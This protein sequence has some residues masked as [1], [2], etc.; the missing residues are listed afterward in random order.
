[1]IF[2]RPWYDLT[3]QQFDRL[4]LVHWS[5]LG[6]IAVFWVITLIFDLYSVFFLRMSRRFSFV[7]AGTAAIALTTLLC[8][9]KFFKGPFADVDPAIIP[10]WLKKVEEVQPLLTISTFVI[11]LQLFGSAVLTFIFLFYLM[12]TDRRNECR[13]GW[14]FI[15]LAAV[16]FFLI[17]LYQIR[18]SA[19]AQIL[20]ILPMTALMVLLRQKGP[21][22]G[23]LK[24][25][26]NVFIVLVF[27]FGFLLL[28]LLAD[29][30]FQKGDSGENR[31]EVSLIR[32]CKYLTDSEKWRQRSFR[33][34]THIDFGSEILYRTRHEV[35][36]TP[37]H[38][39]SMGILDTYEIMTADTDAEAHK[40]IQK[41]NIDL[42]MLCPKSSESAFYS[43]HGHEST[44]YKRLLNDTIPDW[45]RKV[46]LPADLS[47]SFLLF[48][49]IELMSGRIS[50][51]EKGLI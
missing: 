13:I 41:R 19:Y 27:S 7:L 28:G 1:M 39:N 32:M 26:K 47:S 44:F 9:P 10:V 24:T 50:L 2:E 37:Y 3:T 42:I 31:D 35:I 34:L 15:L 17:S 14:L 45:L 43:K 8:Y 16:V 38:R 48:E 23:F 11:P 36:G 25:L 40:L 21:S 51:S 18:W 46:D 6:F 22:T 5:I 33:I 30:I 4:S 20:L 12:L 29:E 49:T